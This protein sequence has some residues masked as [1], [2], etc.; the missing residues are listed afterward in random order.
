MEV[1]N[2]PCHTHSIETVVKMVTDALAR[3]FSQEKMDRGIRTH[4]TSKRLMSKN[5][6]KQDLCKL[7]N[8]RK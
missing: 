1:L 6:S 7:V 3:Y 2:W 5:E 8:F 4:E